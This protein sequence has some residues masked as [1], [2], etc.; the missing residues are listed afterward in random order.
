MMMMPYVVMAS[1]PEHL[2]MVVTAASL[3][4]RMRFARIHCT[5]CNC[6]MAFG[7]LESAGGLCKVLCTMGVDFS[8]GQRALVYAS[9]AG[10]VP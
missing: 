2:D 3:R 9:R 5:M 4:Q 1:I 8:C 10:G 6:Q 7:R